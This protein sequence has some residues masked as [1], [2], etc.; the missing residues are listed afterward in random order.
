[1]EELEKQEQSRQERIAKA[2]KELADAELQL[3]N[4]PLFEPP[5][6]KIVIYASFTH[7]ILI[8]FLQFLIK[9]SLSSLIYTVC[10]PNPTLLT[11]SYYI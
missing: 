3:Q 7:F 6:D 2:E 10:N 8:F 5:K 1:M 11:F 9:N 4:L